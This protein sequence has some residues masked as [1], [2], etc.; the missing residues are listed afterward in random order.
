MIGATPHTSGM[1][2]RLVPLLGRDCVRRSVLG[3]VSGLKR[4]EAKATDVAARRLRDGRPRVSKK[5]LR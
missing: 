2:F 5:D 4:E 3:S 1:R